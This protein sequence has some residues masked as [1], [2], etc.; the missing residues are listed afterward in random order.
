MILFAEDW[1]RYPRAIA[2]VN[3][4]NKSFVR[5][6]S[7]YRKMG[8]KN[9]MF[10]LALHNPDLQ[11]VDP[12][13]PDLTPEQMLMISHEC[14]ENPWY[15]FREIA[16]APAMSSSDGNPMEANRANISL[17]WCFFNHIFYILIQPRQTG[18]SFCTDILMRL[19]TNILC[20]NTDINLL[21]KD[22][23]LRRKN[24]ERL[25]EIVE[26]WPPYLRMKH[27]DDTNNGE[28]L[29]VKMLG[30]TYN[31]H[32]PRSS[33]KDAINMGRGLTTGIMH[34]D[35]GPFQRN[36]SIALPAALAA[37]GAAVDA[38]IA[39][40]APHGVIMTTTAGKK[41]DKDGKYVYK[42][43]SEA[44]PWT[45]VFF[46]AP[47]QAE[48][49]KLVKKNSMGVKGGV[50]RINGTFDH[51]QL[52]K[53]DEWLWKKIQGSLA[54]GL[55]ADRDYFNVW[56]SG[57]E[58]SPFTAADAEKIARSG[59]AEAY[60]EIGTEGYITRWQIPKE[61]IE[62]RM[63]NGQF[64]LGMDTSEASGGDD[65]SLI[66]TDI[67]TMETLAVGQYNETNLILFAKWVCSWFVRFPNVTGIIE[68]RSTGG[69][70]LDYLLLMLP[71][72]GI[73]PFKRLFNRVV[74]DADEHPDRFKEIR[75]P[76][77]RRDHDIYVRMKKTFGFATSG[78]GMA[79]R[80][81]LYSNTLREAVKRAGD[82]VY[83]K[84]TVDQIL[85]LVIRN[86]RIDH[87]AG[88]HDDLVIGWLLNHWL[89]QHG[90]NLDFYGIDTELLRLAVAAK[91][92]ETREE[93]FIRVEQEEIRAKIS[94]VY[95]KL[96]DEDDDYV[97]M[98]LEHELRHLDRRLIV[99][100]E[101]AYSLDELI[102]NV[103][104][105]K[106]LQRTRNMSSGNDWRYGENS[107]QDYGHNRVHGG[108]SDTP[109]T[110]H[111]AW[112]H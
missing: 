43:L 102:R 5:L 23:D 99:D 88:Q 52:G 19:L 49:Y 20:L 100:T 72:Y 64:I 109:Y 17:Y 22:D 40:G 25:K 82:K 14:K 74:Q 76:M 30:N 75:Q 103:R 107:W 15:F 106:K 96:I 90:K 69:M 24:I 29:T 10:L 51:R 47:N 12:Y 31:T 37:M 67:E 81:E 6:A 33:P 11:G 108:F 58:S 70:L 54:E 111:Q 38:A 57:T 56:T 73:D 94:E 95:Q 46:D 63:A 59:R 41:D 89:L 28:E 50:L 27:R 77:G 84:K 101:D 93:Y 105:N 71:Q 61:E 44:A 35:E 9:H 36:I 42:L 39:N 55:D 45:E 26:E 98:R 83:D 87:E 2:D 60:N 48:L 18:K 104:E 79:S 66:L 68:R 80:S 21:T 8:V 7:V 3:T 78:S 34:I 97:S 16:R 85:G 110:S 91:K 92:I 112:R 53:T 4:S 86:G 13:S 65:I 32:V 62:S 1:S